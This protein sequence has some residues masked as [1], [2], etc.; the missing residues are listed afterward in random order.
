[1]RYWR[2]RTKPRLASRREQTRP[3]R[4]QSRTASA[5][6]P[7]PFSRSLQARD[8]KVYRSWTNSYQVDGREKPDPDDVQRMPEQGKAEQPP[9]DG[10]TESLEF[11]LR[12]H[13]GQ[14]DQ[15]GGDVQAVA[16]DE[17]EERR[18][19]SAALR[20]RAAGD[21]VGELM[22]LKIEEC[23]TQHESDQS[24]DVGIESLPRADRQRH[25]TARV[26]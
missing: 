26:A 13:D 17:S 8:R 1:M 7:R 21:H 9:V 3:C 22:D 24:K 2:P 18:E 14:P 20:S 19:K 15:P 4:C 6:A 16:A 11:D 23:G 10:G 5:F 12:H 25:Q